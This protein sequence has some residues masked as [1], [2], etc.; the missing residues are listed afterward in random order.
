MR[1]LTAAAL[2]TALTT[3]FVLA[4]TAFVAAAQVPPVAAFGHWSA[5]AVRTGGQMSATVGVLAGLTVSVLL[6]AT[7][8]RTLRCG[9]DLA[10]AAQ[11]CRRLGPGVA[12]LVVVEDEHP[13]AYAVP[14]IRGRVVVSTAMLRALPAPGRT[15]PHSRSVRPGTDAGHRARSRRRRSR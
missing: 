1:L 14:G 4:V 13:D 3:G 6:G 9:W 8:R 2:V 5:A 15:R 12:G 10:L 7:L 11:T